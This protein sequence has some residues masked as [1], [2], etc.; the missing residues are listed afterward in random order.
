MSRCG[1]AVFVGW[2]VALGC[3]PDGSSGAQEASSTGATTGPTT[4]TGGDTGESGSSAGDDTTGESGSS[5]G[6]DT[7]GAPVEPW[8][9]HVLEECA[10]IVECGC[11]GPTRLPD[12]LAACVAIREAELAETA[13]QGWSWDADCAATR[14]AGLRGACDLAEES[15][16]SQECNLFHGTAV[17]GDPC[18]TALGSSGRRDGSACGPGLTCESYTCVPVCTEVEFCEGDVCGPDEDCVPDAEDNYSCVTE[19]QE[20]G[21]CQPFGG[22]LD[23]GCADG[24][25]CVAELEK[26]VGP[27][28]E[29]EAC[30][31]PLCEVG[32]YCEPW[33]K[34]CLP[35][36]PPGAPCDLDESCQ[37]L[38]CG[39]DELCDAL[40]GEGEACPNRLCAE[41]LVC[42]W[43]QY[44]RPVVGL[45]EA[46]SDEV[47]CG[48][49]LSCVHL[50][51]V[52]QPK[53][54][55]NL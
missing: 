24:L 35:R 50:E 34:T 1:W 40:P 19:Y 29:G 17:L 27:A 39:A 33:T 12:D 30:P 5:T 51:D 49:G 18:L 3:A 28:A 22:D 43:P 10:A 26:C 31:Y 6:D 2:L 41:G 47:Y 38:S 9:E 42:G 32:L 46:C 15:C 25:V 4:S 45:G 11:L 37:T 21:Y 23:P 20:G 53:R 52:C 8:H 48:P 16:E 13:A 14:I 36:L 54:C 55:N 44:C 7:T